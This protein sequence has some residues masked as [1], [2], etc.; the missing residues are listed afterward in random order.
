MDIF[1][2]SYAFTNDPESRR[3]LDDV[4]LRAVREY[5]WVLDEGH[6][7]A[8][9]KLDSLE[10]EAAALQKPVDREAEVAIEW[11]WFR[12]LEARHTIFRILA[13][14]CDISFDATKRTRDVEDEK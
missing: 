13:S 9:R 11:E 4:V 10:R 1:K 3:K 2:L 7:R 8:Q 12:Y 6:E 5:L 14:L